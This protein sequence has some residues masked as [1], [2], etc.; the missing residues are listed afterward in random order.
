MLILY[1]SVK[2]INNFLGKI[3]ISSYY[4]NSVLVFYNGFPSDHALIS[5]ALA[6][7]VGFSR[8][9]VGV[10]YP[11]DILGSFIIAVIITAICVKMIA[12]KK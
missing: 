5:F 4:F 12:W 3:S 6:F 1:H 11:S 8:V 7:L 10:H 2:H 9:Y